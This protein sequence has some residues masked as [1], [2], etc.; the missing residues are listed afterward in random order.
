MTRVSGD[1]ERGQVLIVLAL[2]IVVLMGFLAL[3]VD[4]GNIYAQRRAMQHAADAPALAGAHQVALGA[5]EPTVQAVIHEY[6]Q[7]NGVHNPD[8]DVSWSY[9]TEVGERVGVI[10]TTTAVFSTFF[11]GVLGRPSLAVTASAAARRP[12]VCG[13]LVAIWAE[14]YINIE[15]QGSAFCGNVHSNGDITLGGEGHEILGDITYVSNFTDNSQDSSYTPPTQVAPQPWPVSYNL[16]DYKPGGAMAVAAGG[17]Y[18]YIS[19]DLTIDCSSPYVHSGVLETGLYYTTGSINITCEGLS[20]TIT[21][22]AEGALDVGSAERIDFTSYS[23]GLLF[24]SDY[25]DVAIRLSPLAEK[26]A[27]EGDIFAPKGR[28]EI[29]AEKISLYNG[30][31]VGYAVTFAGEKLMVNF[32]PAYDTGTVF[33]TQ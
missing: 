23:E 7:R 2:S 15:E 31:L 24:F 29:L 9:L 6:A 11:G 20:G 32:N 3:A 14:Q 12:P 1:K 18:H 22:I 25:V 27:L 5:T 26:S 17:D 30:A 21:M 13:G 16:E 19:G 10:V 33:L 28:I 8:D 4:G